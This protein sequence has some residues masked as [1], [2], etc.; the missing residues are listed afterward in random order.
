MRE[1]SLTKTPVIVAVGKRE[2]AE[3]TVSLRRL[4]SN[5]QTSLG[6]EA[7]I[8]SLVDEATPPDIRRGGA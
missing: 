3:R 5:G 6:F 4:G 8:A 7:A 1:H 2:A